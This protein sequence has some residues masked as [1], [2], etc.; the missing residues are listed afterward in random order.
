MA[1]F[2]DNRPSRQPLL[3]APPAV[4]GLIG[5][6]LATHA[7]RVAL[8]GSLPDDIVENYAFIPVRYAEAFVHGFAISDIPGLLVP[9]ISYMF[10]HG[11]FTHVGLNCLWLLV[12]GPAVA[13]RL[14]ARRFFL[15]FLI[16]GIFAALFHLGVYWGSIMAVVGASGGVSGLMGAGMRILYGH[17]M[18]RPSGLAPI[19]SKPLL[20]FSLVWLIANVVTGVLRIGVTDQLTLIAWVAHLGGYFAGL[21]MIAMFPS[22][23]EER[24]RIGTV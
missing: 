18:G 7:I 1:F 14:G 10:L 8:P 12:F 6:L 24:P 17:I 11:D 5:V 13:R 9:F 15:F 22:A 2:Q 21:T 4:L 23:A 19:L 3:N 20:L 16:C